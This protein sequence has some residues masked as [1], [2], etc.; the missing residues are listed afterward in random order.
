MSQ[1]Y[2]LLS[3]S[4]PTLQPHGLQPARLLCPW[5]FPGKNT[6]VGYHFLLHGIFPTSDWTRVSYISYL[7]TGEELPHTQGQGR[8]P[9]GATHVQ[10]VV[11]VRLQEGLEEPSHIE[12]QEGL[13][14]EIPLIQGKEQRLGFAGAAVK[15]YPNPR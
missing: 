15:R 8:R 1:T 4:Y 3:Q 6:G 9:G 14:E 12:G 7:Q 2:T 5:G 13:R 10:G 11:A